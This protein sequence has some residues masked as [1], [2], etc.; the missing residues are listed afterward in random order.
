MSVLDDYHIGGYGEGFVEKATDLAEIEGGE[1][2][3][4]DVSE[5]R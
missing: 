3:D 5:R 4:P 2:N 1:L